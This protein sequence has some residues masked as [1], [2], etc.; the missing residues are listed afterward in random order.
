MN[1]ISSYKSSATLGSYSHKILARD[2]SSATCAATAHGTAIRH[3]RC[4]AVMLSHICTGTPAALAA[5]QA[6]SRIFASASAATYSRSAFPAL[7]A[8]R[9]C[10]IP[11]TILPAA[12][13]CCMTA[14]LPPSVCQS[15]A[16]LIAPLPHI[17]D[18]FNII[19]PRFSI[20][21]GF[22]DNYPGIFRHFFA[23]FSSFFAISR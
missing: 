1:P 11:A 6:S 12:C 20:V 21:N 15:L 22:F 16:A 23:G 17:T 10:R 4:S 19:P 9:D 7:T 14:S 2:Q 13:I 3:M 8:R 18:N 5:A